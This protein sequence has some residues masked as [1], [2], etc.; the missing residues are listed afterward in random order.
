MKKKIDS[1]LGF[2]KKSRNLITGYNT[3]V[4]GLQKRKVRLLIAADDLADNTKRKF[5][6]L[7][8]AAG[9]P[10]RIYGT[11]E[12]LSATTG[13]ADKGIYGVTDAQFAAVIQKEIDAME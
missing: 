3:C 2:A 7:T 12:E 11:V 13:E 5:Q 1:Y 8:E 9:V 4:Y 10:F 6:N